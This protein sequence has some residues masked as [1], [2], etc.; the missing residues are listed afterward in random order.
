M[1][2]SLEAESPV[3]ESLVTESQVT[4]SQIFDEVE[5]YN[6]LDNLEQPLMTFF[7]L[8]S[9]LAF[10]ALSTKVEEYKILFNPQEPLMAFWPLKNFYGF[11]LNLSPILS[12]T[13]LKILDQSWPC[14]ILLGLSHSGFKQLEFD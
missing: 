9:F 12:Q 2:E 1:T 3:T 14:C 4:E 11:N 13:W 7:G 10:L 6:N 5:E 8:L